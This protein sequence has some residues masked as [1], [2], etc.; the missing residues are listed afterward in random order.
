MIKKKVNCAYLYSTITVQQTRVS[1]TYVVKK[2]SGWILSRISV[3]D[4]CK[5]L[6]NL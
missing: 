6:E 5:L 1:I 4:I 2:Q 3:L